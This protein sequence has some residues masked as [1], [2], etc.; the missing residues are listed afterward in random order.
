MSEILV[1]DDSA[2]PA[3]VTVPEDGDARNAASVAVGFQAL[4]NRFAYLKTNLFDPLLEQLGELVLGGDSGNP[5]IVRGN[6]KFEAPP[7]DSG[8]LQL[9]N[10]CY[11]DPNVATGGGFQGPLFIAGNSN[12]DGRANRKVLKATIG[13]NQPVT[14]SQHDTL[15]LSP[16]TTGLEVNVQAET[17]AVGDWFRV[18]NYATTSG[19]TLVV[20]NSGGSTLDTVP[21]AVGVL[22][23]YREFTWD[24]TNWQITGWGTA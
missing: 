6:V 13:A 14:V 17:H 7:S 2:Y 22:P 11:I 4:A 19:R 1:E 23:S 15:I 12:R 5:V 9:G 3:D 21:I 8:G 16:T 24:G 20:K 10:G 18:C